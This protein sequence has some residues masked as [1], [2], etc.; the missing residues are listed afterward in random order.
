MGC[1]C[2]VA[3]AWDFSSLGHRFPSAVGLGG[4]APPLRPLGAG[5]APWHTRGM[6]TPPPQLTG[7]QG[8]HGGGDQALDAQGAEGAT[9]E[10]AGEGQ[11]LGAGDT[12]HR[13]W[14]RGRPTPRGHA[15]LRVHSRVEWVCL[16]LP[17]SWAWEEAST[18]G[19]SPAWYLGRFLQVLQTRGHPNKEGEA[20]VL[21]D[22]GPLGTEEGAREPEWRLYLRGGGGG[23]ARA[24]RCHPEVQKDA[25]LKTAAVGLGPSF[26]AVRGPVGPPTRAWCPP[27]HAPA[28]QLPGC[29]M[30]RRYSPGHQATS[31]AQRGR[32]MGTRLR[33]RQAASGRGT[34]ASHEG[35]VLGPG[36]QCL[37]GAPERGWACC[38]CPEPGS[39]PWAPR[40]L[41]SACCLPGGHPPGGWYG[42]CP[43]ACGTQPPTGL[44][45]GT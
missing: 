16:P 39:P 17:G 14:S 31:R 45:T 4:P 29:R 32:L 23:E 1:T 36:G 24:Q 25:S 8:C 2:C 5:W 26:G 6:G 7:G 11:E 43:S 22:V 13:G 10:A 20:V 18:P 40:A 33:C 41:A 12:G 28:A 38:D 42:G 9:Q 44:C 37:W 34:A 15:G 3:W 27:L 30:G 19:Q 35:P 21:Q